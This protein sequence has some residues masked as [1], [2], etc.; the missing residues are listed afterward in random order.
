MDGYWF[1]SD[2]FEVEPGEDDEINPGIYGRQLAKWLKVQLEHR[3]YTI[4][5]TIKEDWGRCLMCARDPFMLWVGC[6]NMQNLD[7]E[8]LLSPPPTNEAIVWHCFA[9]AEVPFWKRI[10]GKPDTSAA[11]TKLDAALRDLLEHEPR[12]TLVECP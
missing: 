11:V 1:K 6:G 3:G 8:N 4:E 9:T 10:F 12:I 2:L 7:E 5:P